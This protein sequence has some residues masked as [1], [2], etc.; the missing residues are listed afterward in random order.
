VR[1]EHQSGETVWYETGERTLWALA[2]G[3]A[4]PAVEDA[5]RSEVA[6]YHNAAGLAS[7]NDPKWL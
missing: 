6:P 4:L 2:T 7:A 5:G 3:E 1:A